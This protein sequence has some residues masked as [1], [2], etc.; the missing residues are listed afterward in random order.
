MASSEGSSSG[1]VWQDVAANIVAFEV[2]NK[3][4]I[5]LRLSVIDHHGRA[6]VRVLAFAH[7][8][9]IP[10]GEAPPLASASA[11]C[12]GSR[13]KSLEGL[14]IHTLYLLDAELG[15]EEFTKKRG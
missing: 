15:K 10:I 4:R 5:E 6:D 2:I 11:T 14:L 7:D 12:L 9:N 3:V 1:I 13:V 8:R